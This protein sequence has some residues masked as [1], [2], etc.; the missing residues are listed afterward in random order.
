MHYG[1]FD[2]YKKALHHGDHIRRYLSGGRP[3]PL[4]VEIDLTNGCNHRCKFCQWGDYIQ[5]NRATLPTQVVRR[6][7]GELRSL[8]TRS[9]T[10]TGGGEPTV[11]K[12]FFELADEAKALGFENGLL[13]N[14]SLLDP[15]REEQLLS[16]FVWIRVS[17]A[18]GDQESYRAVQGRDDFDRVISNLRRIAEGRARLGRGP[19]IGVAFLVNRRNFCNLRSFANRL[20]EVPI[21]YLQIR[22]DMYADEQDQMWWRETVLPEVA[23][24]NAD[25]DGS[26]MQILGARYMDA[27]TAVAY[28]RKCHA[29]HFVMAIN[30][31]GYVCFCKNTRDKPDF[32]VGN[33]LDEPLTEIWARSQRL[34]ALEHCI[35]PSNCATFC[36]NMDINRAVEDVARSRVSL[37]DRAVETPVHENFL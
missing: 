9:I 36:K 23:L 13:T 18:G 10:W 21:D 31:E 5:S 11:H 12:G 37:E 19:D 1:Q 15:R 27:Q 3:G 7:L 34:H 24:A 2:F 8:G 16:Q 17:M 28:P 22:Q 4:N 30:A 26:P 29:H 25:I 32:Y 20:S 33:I 14:G 6:T 35:N